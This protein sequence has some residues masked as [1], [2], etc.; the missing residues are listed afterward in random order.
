LGED[1]VC[2]AVCW[3]EGGGGGVLQ[4]MKGTQ[5]HTWDAASS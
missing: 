3:G 5:L 1:E 4:H 2:V